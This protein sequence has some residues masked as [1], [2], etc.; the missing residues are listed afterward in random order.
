MTAAVPDRPDLG[1]TDEAVAAA[2]R[3]LLETEWDWRVIGP[4]KHATERHYCADCPLCRPDYG[5]NAQRIVRV[6]LAAAAPFLREQWEQDECERPECQQIAQTA[7]EVYCDVTGGKLSYPTYDTRTILA[8]AN[9]YTQQ[10]IDEA[11]AEQREQIASEIEANAAESR[12]GCPGYAVG[13]E[14]FNEGL[15]RAAAIARGAR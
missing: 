9:D 5:D 1:I 15:G 3:T 14:T 13:N 8:E 12:R 11:L 4:Q 6:V 10:L 7:S 2:A